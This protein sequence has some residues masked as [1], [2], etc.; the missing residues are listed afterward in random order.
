MDDA[1]ERRASETRAG[2]WLAGV[3]VNERV[4]PGVIAIASDSHVIAY[5]ETTGRAAET[6]RDQ[7]GQWSHPQPVDDQAH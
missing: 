6:R 2:G 4:P 5:N 7:H 1:A 3:V